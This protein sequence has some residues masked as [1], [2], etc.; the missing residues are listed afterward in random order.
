M[1]FCAV[2]GE[3]TPPPPKS[4]QQ[5]AVIPPKPPLRSRNPL[6]PLRAFGDVGDDGFN[7]AQIADP[8]RRSEILH[9]KQGRAFLGANSSS[10]AICETTTESHRRRR[11][12]ARLKDI[13]PG[14]VGAGLEHGQ[15]FCCGYLI[16][17]AR[18]VSGGSR[19]MPKIIQHSDPPAMPR[20]SIRRLML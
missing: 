8:C 9:H 13:A 17:N 2:I 7:V 16:R 1:S 4:L 11:W 19:M 14:G 10:R 5:F 20:T 18:K 3:T 6:R 15:T 12:R